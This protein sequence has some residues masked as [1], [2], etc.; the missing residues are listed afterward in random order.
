MCEF[1]VLPKEMYTKSVESFQEKHLTHR[2]NILKSSSIFIDRTWSNR[3]MKS[4]AYP[5]EELDFRTDQ[6]ICTQGR[7]ATHVFFVQRGECNAFKTL[8]HDGKKL[9]MS[10][11]FNFLFLLVH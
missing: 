8:E 6:M 9:T 7:F 10:L 3:E 2:L 1:L 4:I 5:L 11:I